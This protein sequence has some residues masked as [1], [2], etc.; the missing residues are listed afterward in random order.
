MERAYVRIYV[1][2]LAASISI[3]L[4]VPRLRN[5]NACCTFQGDAKVLYDVK[6]QQLRRLCRDFVACCYLKHQNESET[7]VLNF[8]NFDF[9]SSRK[10]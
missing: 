4:M 9:K 10:K 3:R 1:R 8:L 2:K 7:F 5:T 6:C